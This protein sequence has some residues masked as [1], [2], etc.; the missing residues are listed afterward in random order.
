MLLKNNL[1]VYK[2]S[3]KLKCEENNIE[4]YCPEI[5]YCTDNAAMIA[6]AGYYEFINGKTSSLDLNADANL[7][8]KDKL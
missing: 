7:E 4:F 3:L 5:K 8:F 2:N 1:K 6:S